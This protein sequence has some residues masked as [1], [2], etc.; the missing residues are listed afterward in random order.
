MFLSSLSFSPVRRHCIHRA[1]SSN[2]FSWNKVHYMKA[3]LTQTYREIR[4]KECVLSTEIEMVVHWPE[5][6]N[7]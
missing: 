7:L 1:K 3:D 4:F 5:A 6:S 2:Q